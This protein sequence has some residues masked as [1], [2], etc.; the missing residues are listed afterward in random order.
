[1]KDWKHR[2]FKSKLHKDLSSEFQNQFFLRDVGPNNGVN[3]DLTYRCPLECIRC[4]RQQD[5]KRKNLPIWGHDLPIETID[6][7]TDTYRCINFCGQLSD[8]V[9]HPK[10]I[11][12]LELCFKKF[13]N[14]TVHNAS[15]A[16]SEAWYTKAFKAHPQANWWFGIDG[17]PEESHKYRVNQDGVKLFNIMV[18]SKKIL[19]RRPTW[20]YIIFKYNE[21]HKE[22]ARQMA[23][24]NDIQFLFVHSAKWLSKRDP[25]MPTKDKI[26]SKQHFIGGFGRAV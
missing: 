17:L 6:K 4:S 8:P 15:S 20:Q 13:C 23:I 5:F 25:L 10:F 12:I 9:H 21:D 19:L 16:K 26:V 18:N 1:M 7:I 22:Q 24:D 11:E 2:G 14:V 3:I